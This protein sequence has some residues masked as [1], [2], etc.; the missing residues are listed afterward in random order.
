[1]TTT[2]PQYQQFQQ[3]VQPRAGQQPAVPAGAQPVLIATDLVMD[4]SAAMAR[5]Q[6]GRATTGVGAGPSAAVPGIHTLAL[7][8]VSFALVE[9]ES[10]AVM[11][12]SGSGKSTLLHSLAGIIKPTGGSVAFRGA[13]L[14]AMSDADRTKLRRGAF[15]FVFQSGQLL[16]ELPAV[17]NIALPMMLGGMDYRSA[18]DA[19][20]L[21]LERLGL[22]ALAT[23]RPGEM[24][25][26]QMQRIAIAR[27]LAVRP[28]VV[29]ADEPTGA[30]DQATGR[31][32]MGILMEAA[33]ANG[34]AVVVVTHDPNVASFCGRTVIMRDGQLYTAEA[35]AQYCW[36]GGAR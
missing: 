15:G 26:G 19:A 27:A 9:G 1:M 18:T 5:T 2:T 12:P 6:A 29:F 25:G 8:H 4:Y 24:S 28:A 30:L 7:N 23:H 22:R 20:M 31:E 21:W 34:S 32:V 13:N 3:P 14:T 35:A 10:V 36:N 16:P 11:G 17:E 33:Q